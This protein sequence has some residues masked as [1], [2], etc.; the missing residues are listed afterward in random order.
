MQNSVPGGQQR[1]GLGAP[2]AQ[3]SAWPNPGGT[4]LQ[5]PETHPPFPGV[6][7]NSTGHLPQGRK[8][9]LWAEPGLRQRPRGPG[10]SPA[11]PEPPG[12]GE[13]SGGGS[14]AFRQGR[15]RL[16]CG[17]PGWELSSEPTRLPHPS[18]S[19]AGTNP[20][21][22]S[23]TRCGALGDLLSSFLIGFFSVKWGH[24]L[25][26]CFQLP[27]C[28]APRGHAPPAF[29]GSEPRIGSG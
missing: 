19:S 29:L 21:S 12:L 25:L 3:A 18:S 16:S 14:P 20:P 11:S 22:L 26:E 1:W 7:R 13:V 5:E 17:C 4:R 6:D 23:V 28:W 24:N 10:P 9:G 8:W 15:A 2:V 27:G